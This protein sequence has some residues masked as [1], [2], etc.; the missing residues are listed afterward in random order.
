MGGDHLRELESW[1]KSIPSGKAQKKKVLKGREGADEGELDPF[2]LPRNLHSTLFMLRRKSL[3]TTMTSSFSPSLLRD[4]PNPVINSAY[5]IHAV[6]SLP[7]SIRDR[8][9]FFF[10]SLSLLSSRKLNTFKS[11]LLLK[12]KLLL[13]L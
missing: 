5:K 12:S 4:H 9:H 1:R 2:L 7:P 10:G 6:R 13:K 11:P 3:S 8:A